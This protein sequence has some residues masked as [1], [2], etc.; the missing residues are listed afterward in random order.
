TAAK[1]CLAPTPEFLLRRLPRLICTS[2]HLRPPGCAHGLRVASPPTH[3]PP[4]SIRYRSRSPR[5]S[6]PESACCPSSPPAPRR[7]ALP[8]G[9]ALPTLPEPPPARRIARCHSGRG[10]LVC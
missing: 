7:A 3:S 5:S 2:V 10:P 9:A 6:P 8:H 1:F 4:S